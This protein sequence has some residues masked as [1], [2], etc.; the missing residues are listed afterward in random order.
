MED[1]LNIVLPAF[2]LIGLG[3]LVARIGYL[4]ESIGDALADFVF[5]IA[6]PVLLMK[7]IATAEFSQA[8]P[9]I[10]VLVYF[11]GIGVAWL[12]AMLIVRW[13]FKRG[14]RAAVIGGVAAGFSN[15]VLLG[16]PL[17]ERAYG[18]E[19]LQIL[20]FL[21]AIHLP[22]MMA[23]STF[24]MEYAVRSDGVEKGK[25]QLLTI[26][27]NLGRNLLVNPIIIGIFVGIIWR[28]TGLGISGIPAQVMDL[29]AKTTGPLALVSLGMSLIK[30]G[31]KGNLFAA[32]SLAALSLLV[33]PAVVLL[34][35]TTVFTLPLLWTKVAMLAASCPTGVNA[36]LFANHFKN[37]EGLASSTIVFALLG[38]LITIPLWLSLV[39]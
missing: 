4:G 8:N 27:R 11:L 15:L 37:A 13:V 31:I 21:I 23:I 32:V 2:L 22:A 6:V 38:S 5:K 24:L 18:Q 26:G 12:M 28:L 14:S 36:Y 16:I 10:F 1:I 33:M 19:G 29:L 30:F 9:W 39:P 20:L 35:A 17:V 3:Y 34:F 25:I 7:S